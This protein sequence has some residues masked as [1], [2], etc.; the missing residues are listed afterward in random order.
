VIEKNNPGLERK[1]YLLQDVEHPEYMLA[2]KKSGKAARVFGTNLV[3]T[4]LEDTIDMTEEDALDLN[5]SKSSL[6]DLALR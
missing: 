4:T 6:T 3:K 5:L 2:H 1:E